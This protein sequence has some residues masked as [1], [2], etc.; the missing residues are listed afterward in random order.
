[1]EKKNVIPKKYVE[2]RTFDGNRE[3][4]IIVRIMLVT[5]AVNDLGYFILAP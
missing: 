1:L 3:G 2:L 4:A 5:Q